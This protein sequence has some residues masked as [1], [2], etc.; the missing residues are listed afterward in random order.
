MQRK[1]MA[2]CAGAV[3]GVLAL[4]GSATSASAGE[5][6][7]DAIDAVEAIGVALTSDFDLAVAVP[8]AESHVVTPSGGVVLLSAD[9]TQGVEMIEPGGVTLGVGLPFAADAEDAAVV[10]GVM[11]YDNGNGSTT[12]PL[13]YDDGTVQVLTT[14]ADA[15]APVEYAYP[16]DL[17]P[18]A[19]LVL[20]ADGGAEIRNADGEVTATIAAPWAVDARGLSVPT[21]YVVDGNTLTQVVSHRGP[22]TAYPVVADPT[23]SMGWYFYLHFNRAE[24][25][26]IASGGW[27]A[28]GFS[29]LCAGAAAPAGPVAASAIGAACLL[30]FGSIVYT[31]GVAENS[32]PKQCLGVR[33]NVGAAVSFTYRDSRCK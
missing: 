24:T 17:A 13:V 32:S 27:T 12:T 16:L 31:A 1:G 33:W 18:G 20:A 6:Q 2:Q 5:Q 30:Q 9:A 19:R 8:S 10:D 3:F 28:T 26:T 22:G 23:F 21:Y 15:S 7:F 4:I 14:I 29:A 25:K 11:V